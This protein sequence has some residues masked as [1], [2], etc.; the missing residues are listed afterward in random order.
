VEHGNLATVPAQI[1]G[2][3]FVGG[4]ILASHGWHYI[5]QLL[6]SISQKPAATLTI[7]DTI[8]ERRNAQS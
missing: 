1:V 2:P 8:E 6:I 3:T 7:A 4:F 5:R